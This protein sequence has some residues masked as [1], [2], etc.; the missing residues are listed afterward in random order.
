MKADS[1]PSLAPVVIVTS[2]SGLMVLW[3]EDE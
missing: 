2:V 1:M 3:K